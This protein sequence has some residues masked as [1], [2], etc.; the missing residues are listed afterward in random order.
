M[1]PS[2]Q[3]KHATQILQDITILLCILVS[4]LII[5]T[6]MML[7]KSFSLFV[8]VQSVSAAV[9]LRALQVSNGDESL[10]S[11]LLMFRSWADTHDKGYSTEEEAMDRLQV[12]MDNHGR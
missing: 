6:T 9:N 3:T 5:T 4:H 7:Y 10:A 12:W 2:S 8:I 1:N 11:S